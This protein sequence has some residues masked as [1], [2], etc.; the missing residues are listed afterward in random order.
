MF[1]IA[2]P[3]CRAK[4]NFVGPH[5]HPSVVASQHFMRYSLFHFNICDMNSNTGLQTP[6]I[7]FFSGVLQHPQCQVAHAD[8]PCRVSEFGRPY[9][10]QPVRR[11]LG[12]QTSEREVELCGLH[13]RSY[14]GVLPTDLHVTLLS[15]P[16]LCTKFEHNR[17]SRS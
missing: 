14:V 12:R 16:Y 3:I 17:P 6:R 10:I 1:A 11:L 9:S 7:L 2:L 5:F 15:G 4:S 8:F 13:V